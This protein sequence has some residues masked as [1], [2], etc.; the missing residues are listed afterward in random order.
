MSIGDTV[1]LNGVFTQRK[2][3]LIS[4]LDRGFLFSHA[5]YEVTAVYGGKL[6]DFEGHVSRLGNTLEAISIPNPHDAAA[7][8][9]IHSQLIARNGLSEGLIYLE[10]SAG[11]Y[12]SR[13]FAG[14][15]TFTPT[16]FLYA[17]HRPLISEKAEQG[18]RA[19]FL[20]DI[21]WRRRDIKTTQLLSQALAYRAAREA[22]AETAFMVEDGHVTEAA[23]ANTWIVTEEGRIITRNLSSDILPGITRAHVIARLRNQGLDIEERAFTPDEAYAAKE[24]FTTS[25]GA[26]IA[27]VIQLEDRPVGTGKPGPV[28]RQVQRL[29][30]EAIGADVEK[31]AAWALA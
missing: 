1:Y 25:A 28:T 11:A 22:G 30:Y 18:I 8:E 5:A 27:P 24:I 15:E 13:D 6:I 7:W 17:D 29:Y 3:A 10:V 2:D 20:N 12:D 21:R 14:P 23:S 26:M 4:P 16:I 19:I 9:D 31:V